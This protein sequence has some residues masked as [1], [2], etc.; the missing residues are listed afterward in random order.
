MGNA[1]LEANNKCWNVFINWLS[2]IEGVRVA[3]N[4]ARGLTTIDTT[5]ADRSKWPNCLEREKHYYTP[6]NL[7]FYKDI[8]IRARLSVQP[9]WQY[10]R[11]TFP[12]LSYYKLA[13]VYVEVGGLPYDPLSDL[14][15]WDH[16]PAL[17]SKLPIDFSTIQSVERANQ[18][19][20]MD[21]VV[22]TFTKRVTCECE[23]HFEFYLHNN[24]AMLPTVTRLLEDRYKKYIHHGGIGE[25]AKQKVYAKYLKNRWPRVHSY[26]DSNKTKPA[27]EK[28]ETEALI[29][30]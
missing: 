17:S 27:K 30:I 29:D 26:L 10:C 13:E 19:L 16:V 28:S 5:D 22:A 1:Y 14:L 15:N 18:V 6:E 12:Y 7:M 2:Q 24:N 11:I 21:D 25:A 9:S 3:H 4:V 23:L 8:P 20:T